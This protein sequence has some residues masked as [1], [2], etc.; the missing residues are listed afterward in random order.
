[1]TVK[2]ID[3]A[4]E[5]RFWPKVRPTGFCWEWTGGKNASGYGMFGIPKR[6][7][8]TD[9]TKVSAH[10]YAYQSLVGPISEGLVVDHLCRNRGC[11]NPDHLEPVTQQENTLRSPLPTACTSKKKACAQGHLLSGD[12]VKISR[13]QRVCV[14]CARRRGRE[15]ARKSRALRRAS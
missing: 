15:W 10:R 3:V 1:M 2:G 4:T 11:V 8:T 14:E 6:D 5:A 12:N 7:G 9:W 13:G